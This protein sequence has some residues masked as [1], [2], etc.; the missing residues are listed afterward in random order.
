MGMPLS[1]RGDGRYDVIVVGSLR[2]RRVGR[3]AWT[4]SADCILDHGHFVSVPKMVEG[5]LIEVASDE[6]QPYG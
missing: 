5:R 4:R 3:L 6:L 1:E 2:R